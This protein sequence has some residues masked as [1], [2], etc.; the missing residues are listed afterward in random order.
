MLRKG[1]PT[2]LQKCSKTPN[3]VLRFSLL[4]T[5]YD[6]FR[7]KISELW[8]SINLCV[9]VHTYAEKGIFIIL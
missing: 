5:F 2:A 3:G 8:L 9:L 1:M 6:F 4:L 7:D